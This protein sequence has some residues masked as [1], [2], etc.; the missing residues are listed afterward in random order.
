MT[1][2]LSGFSGD[3]MR[4]ELARRERSAAI[5]RLIVHWE[6]RPYVSVPGT[7]QRGFFM[8][9]DEAIGAGALQVARGN[10]ASFEIA[11]VFA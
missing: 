11:E 6:L 5:Q 7:G 2:G 1:F 8:T 9:K 3:D 4:A 10:W